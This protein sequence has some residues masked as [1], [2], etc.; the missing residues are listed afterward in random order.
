M[1]LIFRALLW[2]HNLFLAK[3]STLCSWNAWKCTTYKYQCSKFLMIYSLEFQAISHDYHRS[4]VVIVLCCNKTTRKNNKVF[5]IV[6]IWV[7][8][9]IIYNKA[10]YWSRSTYKDVRKVV[11]LAIKKYI[12]VFF[13]LL[14]YRIDGSR[15]TLLTEFKFS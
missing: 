10:L 8:M 5:K 4:K 7:L 13:G 9:D 1:F 6:T 15:S 11:T 2:T 14:R 12:V 3:E